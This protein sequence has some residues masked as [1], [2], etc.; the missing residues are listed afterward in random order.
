MRQYRGECSYT[1][2]LDVLAMFN[3]QCGQ[4]RREMEKGPDPVGCR[5]SR[6]LKWIDYRKVA[7]L[8]F[9]AWPL[10]G[11]YGPAG[12]AASA[13]TR[14]PALS[15]QS[16]GAN[17]RLAEPAFIGRRKSVGYCDHRLDRFDLAGHL[18]V[19]LLDTIN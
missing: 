4:V 1:R 15:P 18:P 19:S 8:S 11:P 13:R 9:R 5:E 12:E 6:A 14:Q 3:G 2:R 10:P 7:L 17:F 16:A